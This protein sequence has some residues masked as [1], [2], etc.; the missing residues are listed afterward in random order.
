[1]LGAMED[2]VMRTI[3]RHILLVTARK[4]SIIL[5]AAVLE[6][7]LSMPVVLARTVLAVGLHVHEAPSRRPSS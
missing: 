3:G 5:R 2:S 1:M 7:L 4:P 6:H